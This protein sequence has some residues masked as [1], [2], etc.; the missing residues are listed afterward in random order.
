[1]FSH[2]GVELTDTCSRITNVSGRMLVVEGLAHLTIAAHGVVETVIT[3]PTAH[4]PCGQVYRHA[5]VALVGVAIAIAFWEQ[6]NDT[7][8]SNLRQFCHCVNVTGEHNPAGV[9]ILQV[10]VPLHVCVS[11]RSV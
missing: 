11:E 4:I 2:K 7:K 1:M 10:S 6:W 8:V 5:E 9:C 3:D